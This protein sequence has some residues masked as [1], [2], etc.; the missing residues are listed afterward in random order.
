MQ[1]KRRL[2]KVRK[3]KKG[4]KIRYNPTPEQLAQWTEWKN[5]NI[6][7]P[8]EA[9]PKEKKAFIDWWA[10]Q[11]TGIEEDQ[12]V[13]ADQVLS[14]DADFLANMM[15]GGQT[16]TTLPPV[17]TVSEIFADEEEIVPPS[18][19]QTQTE[20]EEDDD[21]DDDFQQREVSPQTQTVFADDFEDNQ[22][23]DE[24]IE[25]DDFQTVYQTTSDT[26]P[27]IPQGKTAQW[28]QIFTASLQKEDFFKSQTGRKGSYLE[29]FKN[30]KQ[31]LPSTK[32][33]G[34]RTYPLPSVTSFGDWIEKTI[35]DNKFETI[36]GKQANEEDTTAW[37][38][39]T[40]Q[41]GTAIGSSGKRPAGIGSIILYVRTNGHTQMFIPSMTPMEKR[42][43]KYW[44]PTAEFVS[45]PKLAWWGSDW[46][47]IKKSLE[48]TGEKNDNLGNLL[49]SYY[50]KREFL[51]YPQM[52]RFVQEWRLLKPFAI[53]KRSLMP[54]LV[55][56]E[57][58]GLP[59]FHTSFRGISSRVGVNLDGMLRDGDRLGESKQTGFS[60]D[61]LNQDIRKLVGM[62][63][64]NPLF[65]Q[66]IHKRVNKR[67]RRK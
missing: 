65:K 5:Q 8:P 13:G 48:I 39:L 56:K 14:D 1:R 10:G 55:F 36:F 19:S 63:Q 59:I 64:Q 66:R 26:S 30:F 18:T 24:E 4:K 20:I 28:D 7:N 33:E 67:R 17:Q 12:G 57:Q 29:R 54:V 49:T 21:F 46:A 3:G 42:G 45:R 50:N 52:L 58:N 60:G 44:S 16:E 32:A 9:T 2:K 35:N 15:G 47:S 25:E 62:M 22:E 43:M 41:H 40:A 23:E 34:F 31:F 6:F 11:M 38:Y 51:S 61:D 27:T 37:G 53:Q